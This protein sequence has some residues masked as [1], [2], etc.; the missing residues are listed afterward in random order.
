MGTIYKN[1]LGKWQHKASRG[2]IINKRKD[3]ANQSK[4]LQMSS[5]IQIIHQISAQHLLHGTRDYRSFEPTSVPALDNCNQL[6]SIR[7]Y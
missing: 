3:K 6:N 4:V 7:K 1:L 2:A 5:N